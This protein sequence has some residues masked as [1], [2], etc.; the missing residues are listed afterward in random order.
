MS[1]KQKI[2]S[3]KWVRLDAAEKES[4][5]ISRPSLTYWQD[6]WRRLKKNKLSMLGLTVIIILTITALLGPF[7]LEFTYEDQVLELANIPPKL[8]VYKVS[9]DFYVYRH[10]DYKLLR[11]SE[12]GE[13]LYTNDEDETY[14]YDRKNSMIDMAQKKRKVYE[15]DGKEVILDY[16][17]A[18]KK[19]FDGPKFFI[20][21]DGEK[22]QPQDRVRNKTYLFGTDH[23]GRD[24]L[25]RVLYGARISLLVALVATLVQFFIGVLYGGIAGYMG[26]KTDNLMMR[27]VDIIATIPLLLYVI[28]LMVVLGAGLGTII[29]ALGLV[30]WVRMA[31]LVRGEVL[32]IKEQ[33]YVM[34]SKTLGAST[35]RILSKHLIPNAMGP[36]IVSL[37][38]SIPSAIFTESFLSFIGLGVS[39]PF[40]SW[41]TLAS[42]A[43]NGIM[44][45]PYQLF[46]PSAAICVTVLSFNFL[47]DGLRDALDPRLRK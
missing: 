12:N 46:Y 8:D 45:F 5:K 43:L 30:Y 9:D 24:V 39:A 37:A 27:I 2:A 42:D 14:A 36:I 29:L 35:W 40:A 19:D 11:V 18:S 6:A 28:L 21:V 38:M 31:R 10:N 33:E 25:A 4:E 13:F 3:E 26:G 23:L 44:S 17:D 7:F 32:R 22:I 34:A 16:A 20:T 1:K 47:G 41:G 15:I